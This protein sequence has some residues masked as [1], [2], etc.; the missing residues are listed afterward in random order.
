MILRWWY[1]SSY[2][3]RFLVEGDF[4]LVDLLHEGFV[5]K[6]NGWGQMQLPF[7]R[8]PL[9][10]NKGARAGHRH[11]LSLF[12]LTLSELF[13]SL[14]LLLQQPRELYVQVSN[15]FNFWQHPDTKKKKQDRNKS[16]TGRG[17][18]WCLADMGTQP[19]LTCF[20]FIQRRPQSTAKTRMHTRFMSGCVFRCQLLQ[21]VIIDSPD[22]IK[23][24]SLA[25]NRDQLFAIFLLCRRS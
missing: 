22:L 21:S 9:H 25:G 17:V 18:K 3:N 2:V 7:F 5:L 13:H 10:A 12:L 8:F 1:N 6:K 16:S 14:H 4:C 11:L 24:P 19:V 20:H 15:V 23:P